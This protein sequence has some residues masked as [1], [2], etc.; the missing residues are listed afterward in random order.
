VQALFLSI[1]LA[2]RFSRTNQMI[3]SWRFA[4]L[5]SNERCRASSVIY[6]KCWEGP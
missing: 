2:A 1:L 3:S 5:L 4:E 6:N